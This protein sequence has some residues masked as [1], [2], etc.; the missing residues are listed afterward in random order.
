[1]IDW[2][3][4]IIEADEMDIAAEDL[5]EIRYKKKFYSHPSCNDPEH[6][7]CSD[8]DEECPYLREDL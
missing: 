5:D 4:F 2:D 7:G 8:C 1:M 3:N 6:P